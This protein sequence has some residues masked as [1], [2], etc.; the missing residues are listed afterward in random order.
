[1]LDICRFMF[2]F[3]NILNSERFDGDLVDEYDKESATHIVVWNGPVR[4]LQLLES[5]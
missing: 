1:M 2:W 4:Y 5:I 3:L